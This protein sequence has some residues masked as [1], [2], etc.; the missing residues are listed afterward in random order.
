MEVQKL[1]EELDKE[2]I[3]KAD[4]KKKQRAQANEVIKEN[5]RQKKIRLAEKDADR[6]KQ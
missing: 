6:I 4:K 1:Q 5:E 3:E 2:K